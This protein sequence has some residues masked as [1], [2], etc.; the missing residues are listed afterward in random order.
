MS[1]INSVIKGGAAPVIDTLNVTPTTSAQQITAPQGTDGYSPVNVSAVTSSIDANIV[2]GNIKKDVQILGVTGSYEGTT[3]TGT[4][5]ITSNG[6]TDVSGYANADVQVP[7]TAP[8][9]YID[10]NKSISAG[11]INLSKGS[12]L[13]NFSDVLVGGHYFFAYAYYQNTSITGVV[14]LSKTSSV[15]QSLGIGSDRAFYYCFYGCTGIT[16][17]NFSGRSSLEGDYS[18]NYCFYGCTGITGLLDMST[19]E[20]IWSPGNGRCAES[21]FRGCTGITSVDLSSLYKIVGSSAAASMFF[22]CTNLANIDISSLV[23]NSSGSTMFAST[24]LSSVKFDSLT[25]L[26]NTAILN[27]AFQS[28]TSLTH[29][30]FPCI[31]LITVTNPWRDMLS[32]V[33]GCTIHFPKNLDPQTGDTR[34]SSLYQY[35]NFGGTNTVLVFDQPSTYTLTGANSQEYYRNPK[36]DTATAL[37]WRKKDTGSGSSLNVDFTPF[38]TNTLNDPQVN[39]TIYSDSACTVAVTTISSIA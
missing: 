19:I 6:I 31:T 13:M 5:Q 1:I 35:P 21:M 30:Y 10:Y 29:L 33:T 24:A 12:H 7:T 39:D 26:D 28:C 27:G 8:D 14:N 2:A 17:V 9:Y 23:Y 32:G 34:I 37:A 4:K 20:R 22:G 25:Y 11:V 18:F 15:Q 36:Y 16:G 3:P 38:Y